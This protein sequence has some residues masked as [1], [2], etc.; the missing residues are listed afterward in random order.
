MPKRLVGQAIWEL[1][2]RV[3]NEQAHLSM[4][5]PIPKSKLETNHQAIFE[6]TYI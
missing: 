4:Y 6:K 5:E 1:I 2:I 3:T